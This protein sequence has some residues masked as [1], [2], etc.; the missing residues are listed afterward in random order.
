MRS[1]VDSWQDKQQGKPE[2][3]A[4]ERE[5]IDPHRQAGLERFLEKPG[6]EDPKALNQRGQKNKPRGKKDKPKAGQE[7]QR[8][9]NS[10][11]FAAKVSNRGTT[12]RRRSTIS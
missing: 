8:R 9:T 2:H 3:K 4:R 7:R 12:S 1:A 11:G 6:P 5:H 10:V